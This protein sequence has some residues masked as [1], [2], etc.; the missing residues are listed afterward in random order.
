MSAQ[1]AKG[2]ASSIPNEITVELAEKLVGRWSFADWVMFGKNGT[3]VTTLATRIA[4]VYTGNTKILAA[5]GAYHGFDTWSNPDI[6]G[7]PPEYRAHVDYFRWNNV[8]SVRECFERNRGD[9]AGVIICPIK[10]DAMHD[11]E[12]PAPEFL[13]ALAECAREAGALLMIDDIRCGF[14]LHS[15]GGSHV[16]FGIEPDLVCFGKALGNGEPIAVLLGREDYREVAKRLYF[17]ATHFFSAVP[18]AAA[19]ATLEAFDEEG[20]YELIQGAG[21]ALR[22]GITAAAKTAGVGISYTGP[23]AM[24][25]LILDDDPQFK[26]GRSFS[27]LAARRGVIF[28]PRHNWFISSAH[29]LDDVAQAV[30]VAEECFG[31]VAAE[32]ESGVLA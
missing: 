25:N 23:D 21:H 7:F 16:S 20:A 1:Q 30:A 29:T 28:H 17:S 27:G 18:M 4:R 13:A 11:I 5:E 26:R 14:R 24:P 10:H 19:L 22:E 3:D 2:N 8:E 31:M 6:A 12:M 15:S 9:V 32:I